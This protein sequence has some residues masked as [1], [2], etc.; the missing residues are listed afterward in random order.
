MV[1]HPCRQSQ[2]AH[3]PSLNWK[4][5]TC[6]T[7]DH[8]ESILTLPCR[9]RYQEWGNWVKNTAWGSNCSA[10]YNCGMHYQAFLGLCL[11]EY[12]TSVLIAADCI[13][14]E[15]TGRI[16]VVPP[17]GTVSPI[18]YCT[19]WWCMSSIHLTLTSVI[20]ECLVTLICTGKHLPFSFL[21]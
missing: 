10:L 14:V 17:V 2:P 20:F 7:N 9:K 18:T 6:L 16:T 5:L 15:H 3:S 11:G 12:E 1:S 21:I 4:E 13:D 8:S 19:H